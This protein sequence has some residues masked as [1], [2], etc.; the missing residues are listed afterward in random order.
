MPESV[1]E[2]PAV[3]T[4]SDSRVLN[5]LLSD[6]FAGKLEALSESQSRGVPGCIHLTRI[7]ISII[8]CPLR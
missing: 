6:Q 3:E 2:S 4:A 5:A 1:K 8:S 7:S